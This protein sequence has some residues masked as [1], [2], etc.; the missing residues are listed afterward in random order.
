[1]QALSV[2]P[3]PMAES[4]SNVRSGEGMLVVIDRGIIHYDRLAAGVVPG[5]KLLVLNVNKDAIAQITAALHQAFMP[6]SSLHI[7]A[8]GSPGVLHFASGD[9]SLETL[10]SYVDQLRTW[11]VHNSASPNALDP[12]IFLYGD[13]IG[14]GQAGLEFGDTLTWLTGAFVMTAIAQGQRGQWLL[15]GQSSDR[16]AF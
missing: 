13:R 5:A 12:E 7:I 6:F 4:E 8:S 14:T 3:N 2:Y 15:N 1:M 10:S 11:F 9:F 16:L